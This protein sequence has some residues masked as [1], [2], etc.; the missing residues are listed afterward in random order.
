MSLRRISLAQAFLWLSEREEKPRRQCR[1]SADGTS[2]ARGQR[3]V[4]QVESVVGTA[5]VGVKPTPDTD[6][7]LDIAAS[8][9]SSLAARYKRRSTDV[10][11]MEPEWLSGPSKRF[12]TSLH[13][14]G[15]R[16]LSAGGS[17]QAV[18]GSSRADTQPSLARASSRPSQGDIAAEVLDAS[19]R[20]GKRPCKADTDK[21]GY[22]WR[23][24]PS[25]VKQAA[26]HKV[27][28]AEDFEKNIH[29][30][31]KRY[32]W[33]T[34]QKGVS[35][36]QASRQ[37]AG[38]WDRLHEQAAF[39]RSVCNDKKFNLFA[40]CDIP[41]IAG[42]GADDDG[43]G[44]GVVPDNAD[45]SVEPHAVRDGV[46]SDEHKKPIFWPWEGEKKGP[47]TSTTS[48]QSACESTSVR[49]FQTTRRVR[50]RHEL[51]DLVE[52]ALDHASA[53]GQRGRKHVGVRAWFSFCEDVMGVSP[54]RPMDPM[55]APLWEKLEEEWLG[56]QFVCALVRDRGITP[57]SAGQYFSSF[58]GWHAREH[59]VKLAGTYA[60]SGVL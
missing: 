44:V 7:Q 10:D 2:A 40:K 15:F 3:V 38:S 60:P 29:K 39:E 37:A 33:P 51:D 8:T 1:A 27:R 55:M 42:G 35:E 36:A 17:Q 20:G 11:R 25:K 46:F 24:Q 19:S 14:C 48:W 9:G 41:D 5:T 58:Q 6:K 57:T 32:T 30:T 34:L 59:G 53:D 52:R 31:Q 45:V 18:G 49:Q 28:F 13:E 54:H 23:P 12:S 43:A 47:S 26:K 16:W 56:M 22:G 21:E 4:R 50:Q